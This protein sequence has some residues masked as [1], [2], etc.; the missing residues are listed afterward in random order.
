MKTQKTG[1]L[2]M[3]FMFRDFLYF[4]LLGDER[5]SKKS[6]RKRSPSPVPDKKKR[7]R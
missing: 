1:F 3:W 7:K 5:K 6:K 4:Q 2:A